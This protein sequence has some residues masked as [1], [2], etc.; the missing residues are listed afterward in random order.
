MENDKAQ[1]A[2]AAAQPS[3]ETGSMDGVIT[4]LDTVTKGTKETRDELDE[5]ITRLSKG[6]DKLL[7]EVRRLSKETEKLAGADRRSKAMYKLAV[8][9]VNR[10]AEYVNEFV[11]E[12]RIVR[13]IHLARKMRRLRASCLPSRDLPIRLHSDVVA[14]QKF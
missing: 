9:I 8:E 5:G 4:S 1:P 11:K 3:L 12:L 14:E 6:M 7:K 10:L 2:T 13:N